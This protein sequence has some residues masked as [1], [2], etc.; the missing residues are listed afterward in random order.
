[1]NII[2]IKRALLSVSDKTGLIEFAQQLISLGVE[3]ISTGGT[4]QCLLQAGLPHR[5]VE[6]ITHLPA[7]LGGRVKTLHPN[8]HGGILGKRN[9]HAEEAA[10]L[11]IEWIDLVVVN[12]YP[13]E[14]ITSQAEHTFD[15]AIENIDIGG[16]TMV[17]AAAKN[18]NW[19]GIVTNPQDY[20][21]ILSTLASTSGLDLQLRR[22]LAEKA[23]AMTA[24]YDAMIHHYFSQSNDIAD[25]KDYF[26]LPLKKCMTLRYGENPH[27]K[28]SAYQ[29]NAQD[30]LLTAKQHQG[31]ELSYN[32]LLDA[33][34]ALACVLEFDLPAAVVVKHTNPCGVA[35]GDTIEEAFLRAYQADSVSAFGGIVTLNRPCTEALA[36][37]LS[38]IFIEVLIA[39]AYS[40]AALKKLQEKPNLR[41]LELPIKAGAPWEMR[42]ISGGVL[43]Q[44]RDYQKITVEDLKIVTQIKPDMQQIAAMLFAWQVVKHIKSNG[45]LIANEQVTVGIGAGQVSRIDAVEMAIKKA[46]N[47]VK[48]AVLA[49]DAFFPFRDSIDHI[50]KSG[51]KAVIQPGGSMR[52]PEVIAACNEHSIAMVFTGTRC[53]RH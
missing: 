34:A 17:R 44:E 5:Q 30:G 20:S 1:M 28:A 37:Q 33:E 7:I 18:F 21:R 8:I 39:P 52:D 25:F 22:Q 32:N 41:V 42:F 10:R 27:Q 53:F 46:K 36:L 47:R 50:A 29:F 26:H 48:G 19:V 11:G 4:S 23:F 49:S 38:T 43:F 40:E 9:E 45:I 35:V 51:I 15:E 31:K 13:F 14:K 3:V 12:F 6:D 16:P 2:P 24:A